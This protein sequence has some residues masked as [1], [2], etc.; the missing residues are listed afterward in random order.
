MKKQDKQT[1]K[2][3]LKQHDLFYKYVNLSITEYALAN[4]KLIKK[5]K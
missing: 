3:M 2:D 1:L 5:G 4:Q